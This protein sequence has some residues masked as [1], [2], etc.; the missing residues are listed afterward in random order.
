MCRTGRFDESIVLIKK[1]MRMVHP[2]YPTYQL[3]TLGWAQYFARQYEEAIAMG[4]ALLE[5]GGESLGGKREGHKLLAG[6]YAE[7]GQDEKARFHMT[8]VVRLDPSF[9]LETLKKVLPMKN[10]S[11][12]ERVLD[13]ARKAGAPEKSPAPQVE[14]STTE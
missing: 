4:E 8:E 2:H 3:V 12:L 7:I 1:A 9:S 5:L 13:A 14:T 6:T 11:D 10:S